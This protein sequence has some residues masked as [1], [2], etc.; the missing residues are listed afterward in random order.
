MS[1]SSSQLA[2]F[3]DKIARDRALTKVL[4]PKL[5]ECLSLYYVEM[6]IIDNLRIRRT[7]CELA[8]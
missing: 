8:L 3:I 4:L 1:E 6:N 7:W 2:N 5:S